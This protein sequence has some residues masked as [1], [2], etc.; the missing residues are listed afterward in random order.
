MQ[1]GEKRK[2]TPILKN[3]PLVGRAFHTLHE[4]G[5]WNWQG[6]V[7]ADC[8]DGYFLVQLFDWIAGHASTQHVLSLAAMTATH[9]NGV[10]VFQF[11][12]NL[13]VANEFAERKGKGG[14]SPL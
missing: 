3:H 10:P 13:D 7:I 12:D 1:G 14:R 11:F 2:P 9:A 8:G 5:G 4:D 6:L